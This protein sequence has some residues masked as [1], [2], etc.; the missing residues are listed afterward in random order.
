MTI[1]HVPRP[2]QSAMDPD[3]PISS[4]LKTQI[5][6]L[7]EAEEKLPSRYR[8][9][10]YVNAI[11]TEGEAGAYIRDVT[12]AI[13]KAHAE[14]GTLRARRSGERTRALEIAAAADRPVRK[15]T[16]LI[17]GKRKATKTNRRP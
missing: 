10:I 16:S 1:I 7:R 8:T 11:K 4:L 9:E 14:A 12:Q 3:R 6:H 2:P 5:E 17:K 15:R 13:H